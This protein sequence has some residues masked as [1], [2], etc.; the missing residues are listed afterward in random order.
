M[1]IPIIPILI[2]LILLALIWW[3][4]SQLVTDAFILRII[5]VVIVVLVV[6]W[7]VSL[8]GG[9]PSITFR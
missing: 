7:I 4:A 3:V 6:L 2:A 8:L 1:A 9:G 5:R